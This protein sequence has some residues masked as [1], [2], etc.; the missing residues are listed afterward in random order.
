[1]STPRD[2]S[3][4]TKKQKLKRIKS[5]I[6]L[7]KGKFKKTSKSGHSCRSSSKKEE[8]FLKKPSERE[9]LNKNKD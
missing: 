3:S 7:G 9:K 4:T 5:T 1:M 6:K 8:K 2:S